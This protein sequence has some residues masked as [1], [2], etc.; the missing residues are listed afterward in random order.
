MN[1]LGYLSLWIP[2][3]S[4]HGAID[5]NNYEIGHGSKFHLLNHT[6]EIVFTGSI[7]LRIRPAEEETG[8]IIR[9]SYP[10]TRYTEAIPHVVANVTRSNPAVITAPNHGFS[11]GD[12]VVFAGMTHYL[13]GASKKVGMKELDY[14]GN[15]RR[16]NSL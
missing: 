5:F 10:N 13:R 15:D 12:K 1:K 8:S 6:D 9:F 11:D 14:T 2:G 3:A 7:T 16:Q 4:T